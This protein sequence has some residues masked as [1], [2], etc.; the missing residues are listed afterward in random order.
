MPGRQLEFALATSAG[1]AVCQ[2]GVLAIRERLSA[3]RLDGG[4]Y[5]HS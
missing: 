5:H 2:L 3:A 1:N 4:R